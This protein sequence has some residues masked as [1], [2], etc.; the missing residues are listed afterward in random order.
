MLTYVVVRGR[1]VPFLVLIVQMC[2]GSIQG[3]RLI[4][5]GYGQ[6]N[7]THDPVDVSPELL[8]VDVVPADTCEEILG[9]WGNVKDSLEDDTS[10]IAATSAVPENVRPHGLD[11][12]T[13]QGAAV[14]RG[15]RQAAC[16]NDKYLHLSGFDLKLQEICYHSGFGCGKYKMR[17]LS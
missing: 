5:N 2:Q 1:D 10:Q 15:V 12:D 11:L 9:S 3:V 6:I 7:P 13:L 4:Q 8:G 17:S 14:R 16:Q